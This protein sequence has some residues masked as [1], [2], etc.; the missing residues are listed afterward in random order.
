MSVCAVRIIFAVW[1]R[2]EMKMRKDFEDTIKREEKKEGGA[3]V[4]EVLEY[5]LTIARKFSDYYCGWSQRWI[6]IVLLK[7][8]CRMSCFE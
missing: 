5:L 2:T 7:L 4:Q 1:L 6:E 8:R 3:R